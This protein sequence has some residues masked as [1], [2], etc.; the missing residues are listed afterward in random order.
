MEAEWEQ[1]ALTGSVEAYLSYRRREKAQNV[2][3]QTEVVLGAASSGKEM[4][5]QKHGT[6]NRADWSGIGCV[7]LWGLR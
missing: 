6:D 5:E 2:L 7:P 3:G 1:F 4:R